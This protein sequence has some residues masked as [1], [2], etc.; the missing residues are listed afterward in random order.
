[1]VGSRVLKLPDSKLVGEF[2]AQVW[3][4]EFVRMVKIKP[5][6]ATD[7]AT[8]L[9]WF[10]NAIMAGYDKGRRDCD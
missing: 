6:I 10:A 1:M 7:E 8:M 4:E 9:T 2:D 3:A 5:E